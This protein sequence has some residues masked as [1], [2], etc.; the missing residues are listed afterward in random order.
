MGHVAI[1]AQQQQERAARAIAIEALEAIVQDG[2]LLHQSVDLARQVRSSALSAEEAANQIAQVSPE[3]AAILRR[4]RPVELTDVVIQLVIA[5]IFFF[6][7]LALNHSATPADV[8]G[9]V[10]KHDHETQRIVTQHDREHEREMQRE[11][12]DAVERALQDCQRQHP[13]AAEAAT[14]KPKNSH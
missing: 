13:P 12:Q 4:P 7:G 2:Q 6:A 5:A 10:S 14:P 9:I 1:G 11:I 8:E 3:V